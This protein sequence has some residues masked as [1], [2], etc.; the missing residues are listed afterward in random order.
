MIKL[1]NEYYITSD[2]YQYILMRRYKPTQIPKKGNP[3]EY[4]ERTIGYFSSLTL[5]LNRYRKEMLMTAVSSQDV[6]LNEFIDIVRAI[7]RDMLMVLRRI[8][9]MPAEPEDPKAIGGQDGVKS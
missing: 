5:T 2:G 4:T 1:D 3:K 9:Q 7:D 8:D 6:T